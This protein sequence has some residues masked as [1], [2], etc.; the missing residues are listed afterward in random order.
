M[1]ENF[2]PLKKPGLLTNLTMTSA[3]CTLFEG[4]YHYGVAALVNS[5]YKQGFRGSVFAGYRG[6]LPFWANK[7]IPDNNLNWEGATTFDVAPEFQIHFLPLSTDYHFTNYKPDF[8]LSLFNGPASATQSLFY[9]DPD[10][11]VTAP[12]SFFEEWVSCGVALCEDVNSPLSEHHPRRTVWRRNFSEK[13][14]TL[15][16]KNIIYVNAGFI[17]LTRQKLNFLETWQKLQEAMASEIGGL[18]RCSISER[19]PLPENAHGTF[20]PFSKTD[21]DALNAAIEAWDG[22]ISFFGKEGMAFKSGE[23]LMPHALGNPKPWQSNPLLQ[24]LNGY[25]PRLVDKKYW[26]YVSRPITTHSSGFIRRRKFSIAFA[27]LIGRFYR[28]GEF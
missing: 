16:F 22:E 26:S 9:F 11:V 6:N 17:G 2:I 4:H 5:L 12:W 27:A 21:Q 19:L 14:F 20:F 7:T 24:I 3:V 10:I 1:K 8:M 23:P 15:K 25:P 18:N 13:G 28:R